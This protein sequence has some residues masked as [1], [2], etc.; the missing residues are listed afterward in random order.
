MNWT[1]KLAIAMGVAAIVIGWTASDLVGLVQLA[2]ESRRV[3]SAK[4]AK[5]GGAE[6]TLPRD[7]NGHFYV[8]AEINGT[9]VQMLADTGASVIALG[10]DVADD[11]GLDPDSLEYTESVSTANGTAAAAYVELDEVR[12]GSIVRRDVKAIVT[13]G[14]RGALLGMSFFNTLSKV[15][16]E[17][18]ELVLK[19]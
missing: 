19:D 3:H 7:A 14:L 18:D 12:V 10:E 11:V 9:R 16:I 17:S 4:T 5:S 13:R 6:I 8:D 1:S 15:S 2:E